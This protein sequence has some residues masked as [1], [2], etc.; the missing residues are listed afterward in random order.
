MKKLF[1]SILLLLSGVFGF[2]SDDKR[3]EEVKSDKKIVKLT[4]PERDCELE[5]FLAYSAAL[6]MFGDPEFARQASYSVY[7]NCL[8]SKTIQPIRKL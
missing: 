7:F 5:R 6:S 4:P 8:G 2:A 3:I 1:L